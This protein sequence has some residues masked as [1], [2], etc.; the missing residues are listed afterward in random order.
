MAQ[1]SAFFS[2]RLVH[3]ENIDLRDWEFLWTT[4]FKNDSDY[5]AQGSAKKKTNHI[6]VFLLFNQCFENYCVGPIAV[7]GHK[8]Q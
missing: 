3:L 8:A 5:W 7:T 2:L 4:A 6:I 1:R